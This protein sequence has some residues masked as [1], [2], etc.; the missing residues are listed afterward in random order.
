MATAG[1]FCLFW[2]KGVAG[3]PTFTSTDVSDC[4]TAAGTAA[5][6]NAATRAGPSTAARILDLIEHL[7]QSAK[8]TGQPMLFGP[9]WAIR[10][11]S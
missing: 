6:A 10:L 3:L 11:S 9:G 4:A 7:L 8:I 1:S 5:R 2:E